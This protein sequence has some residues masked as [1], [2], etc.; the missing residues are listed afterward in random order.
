MPLDLRIIQ[1]HLVQLRQ[2]IYDTAV[3]AGRDPGEILILPVTKGFTVEAVNLACSLGF[4][5]VGENY[6]QEA[7]SKAESSPPEV[8]WNLIGHLQRNKAKAAVDLFTTISSVDS[9]ALAA[10]LERRAAAKAKR[11]RILIELK[12]SSE[13]SKTGADVET[14]QQIAEFA[15]DS[16]HL[17]LAGVMTI[18]PLGA[19]EATARKCFARAR[20]FADSISSLL[21]EQV[22]SFGMSDDFRAAIV[23]GST[24]IRVGRALFGERPN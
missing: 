3:S 14:G 5:E 19:N 24:Q 16:Q 12:T 17:H 22:L 4:S 13:A 10:E 2:Q 1:E 8:K 20:R 7:Q 11:Q 21:R 15:A 23:E 18:A 6:V 9:L